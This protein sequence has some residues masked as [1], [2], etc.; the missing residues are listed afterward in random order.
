MVRMIPIVGDMVLAPFR[1]IYMCMRIK[2]E[3]INETIG[4]KIGSSDFKTELKITESMAYVIEKLIDN[5][6][7]NGRLMEAVKKEESSYL[8]GFLHKFDGVKEEMFH[9]LLGSNK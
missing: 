7:F 8:N 4:K 1:I 9:E 2:T 5:M 3:E 6:E